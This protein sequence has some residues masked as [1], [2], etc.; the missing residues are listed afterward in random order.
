MK[1]ET[2][3]FFLSFLLFFWSYLVQAQYAESIGSDRPGQALSANT[4]GKGIFQWQMGLDYG[5]YSVKEYDYKERVFS[6]VHNFRIGIMERVE[7][8]ADFS[9]KK[10]KQKAGNMETTVFNG[11][12]DL[13]LN[14]RA[15]ILKGK[16]ANPALAMHASMVKAD[17][18][19]KGWDAKLV[20][21]TSQTF[22][23]SWGLSINLGIK[24]NVDSN[25]ETLNYVLNFNKSFNNGLLLFIEHYGEWT[26]KEFSPKFDGGMAFALNKNFQIDLYGGYYKDLLRLPG[27]GPDV[28]PV[29]VDLNNWFVSTG[30]SWRIGQHSSEN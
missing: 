18:D 11:M 25:Y 21:A 13:G 1:S 3:K 10:G 23:D 17:I 27:F 9:L 15:N 16:N 29:D 12:Y 22:W 2:I 7:L 28:A 14:M 19:Q 8:G 5:G 6:N 4:V 26:N 30:L 24:S 20:I